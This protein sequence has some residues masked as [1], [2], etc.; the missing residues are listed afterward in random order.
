[1]R[2]YEI[3]RS[4]FDIDFDDIDT[5]KQ[6]KRSQRLVE[7]DSWQRLEDLVKWLDTG[8]MMP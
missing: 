8:K 6:K 4:V 3:D 2:G 7:D 5:K 1:V